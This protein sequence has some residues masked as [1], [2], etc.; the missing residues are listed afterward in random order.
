MQVKEILIRATPENDNDLIEINGQS[1]SEDNNYEKTVS[2]DKGKNIIKI[3]VENNDNETYILNVYRGKT[4]VST[5]SDSKTQANTSS[6]AN[7]NGFIVQSDIKKFN[8]WQ[9]INEK[10]RYIDGTGDFLKSTWW[11]DKNTG[12]NYYLKED[13][14]MA[15]G[16]LYTNNNWYY[17]G[18]NGE[19]QIGWISSDGN[20]Y[21]LNKSGVMQTGWLQDSIGNWYYLDGAGKMINK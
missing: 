7:T 17:F 19:M 2:L 1:L 15:T 3:Y 20:W 6:I 8:A 5:T 10:W 9:I 21:Y 16:W 14:Y 13:G 4:E 18:G 12:K 11:F